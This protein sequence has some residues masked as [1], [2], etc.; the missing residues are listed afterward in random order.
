MVPTPT[1][2]R[3]RSRE[4]RNQN[5]R[6]S[7]RDGLFGAQD[8][9]AGSCR[10]WSIR[11]RTLPL[12]E[13]ARSRY[14]T[15]ES[16]EKSLVPRVRRGSPLIFGVTMRCPSV[17]ALGRRSKTVSNELFFGFNVRAPRRSE[18]TVKTKPSCECRRTRPPEERLYPRAGKLSKPGYCSAGEAKAR[19]QRKPRSGDWLEG[20]SALR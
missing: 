19:T 15:R 10:S 18:G 4:G 9:T 3:L 1:F 14:K 8:G 17:L 20:N 11:H 16:W 12:D 7:W 6:C 13:G 2:G 5:V